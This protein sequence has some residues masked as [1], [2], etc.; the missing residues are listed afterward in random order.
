MTR[1]LLSLPLLFA[2]AAIAAADDAAN[3]LKKLVGAWEEVSHIE[4][5]KDKTAGEIKG[6]TVVIDEKGNWQAL[7]DGTVF[8]K[9]SSKLDPSKKPRAADWTVEGFD[10]P[11]LGIYEV[12]KDTWKHCFALGKRP[13]EFASKEG[14]GVTYIV[15]KRVKK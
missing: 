10:Q 13:T 12:D 4:N 9:G 15:L 2:F 3:D 7:K 14:S 6:A 5:G 11:V 8:L 1:L